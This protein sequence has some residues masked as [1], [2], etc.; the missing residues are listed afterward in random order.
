MLGGPINPGR[1]VL[2]T[3]SL[4]K[5]YRMPNGEFGTDITYNFVDYVS[6]ANVFYVVPPLPHSP[7][8]YE[9]SRDGASRVDS[10]TGAVVGNN[11]ALPFPVPSVGSMLDLFRP[12]A[13]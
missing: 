2:Q 1:L 6:G 7:G 5:M 10:V 8:F 9:V 12:S 11:D 13:V 4:R 3:Y